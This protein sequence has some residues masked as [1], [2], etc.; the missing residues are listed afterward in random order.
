M[1]FFLCSGGAIKKDIAFRA[2]LPWSKNPDDE[3]SPGSKSRTTIQ[4]LCRPAAPTEVNRQAEP[5]GPPRQRASTRC[6]L[7]ARPP[8]VFWKT[9]PGRRFRG[10]GE[11]ELDFTRFTRCTIFSPKR[12]LSKL[13]LIRHLIQTVDGIN[14]ASVYPVFT[15]NNYSVNSRP[16]TSFSSL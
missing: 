12:F 8:R 2:S 16:E 6:Q 7:V 15:G 13:C 4:F 10:R 1:L 14:V 9:G 11:A 5:W 3:E